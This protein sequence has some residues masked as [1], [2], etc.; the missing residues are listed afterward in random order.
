MPRAD[1]NEL[2]SLDAVTPARGSPIYAQ[3]RDRVEKLISDGTLKP[4]G[5]LPPERTLATQLGIS[6]HSLRQALSALEAR[7]LL[8][9]R[10][11]SGSYLRSSGDEAASDLTDALVTENRELPHIVE[12]RYAIERFL[13]AFAARRRTPLDLARLEQSLAD[14]ETALKTGASGVDSD[15]EFH[16]RIAIAAKS[17]VL[18]SSLLQLKKEMDRL[19]EETLAQPATIEGALEHHRQIFDAIKRGDAVGASIAM[20]QHILAAANTLLASDLGQGSLSLLAYD[21]QLWPRTTVR[22]SEASS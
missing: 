10:H 21:I 6:R 2:R 15:R 11:G 20:E 3:V 14:M 8:E 12:A 1:L 19:R 4:G 18:R 9:I 16:D 17:P 22:K 13:A 7:G 5:Q